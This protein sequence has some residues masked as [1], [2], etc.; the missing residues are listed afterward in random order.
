MPDALHSDT[1][2]EIPDLRESLSELIPAA[3]T[4]ENEEFK[5]LA[6]LMRRQ[7][8]MEHQEEKTAQNILAATDWQ[9][10]QRL[11]AELPSNNLKEMATLMDELALDPEESESETLNWAFRHQSLGGD[12]LAGETLIPFKL[13]RLKQYSYILL[14]R[15][16]CLEAFSNFSKAFGCAPTVTTEH[17]MRLE[18]HVWVG[19][20]WFLDPDSQAV[21]REVDSLRAIW[22]GAGA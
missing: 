17:A 12:I 11:V 14:S 13:I 15:D 4:L 9:A 5:T 3:S 18:G 1:A 21:Q 22:E 8:L 20:A 19:Y 10:M 6:G 2:G 16:H 7:V